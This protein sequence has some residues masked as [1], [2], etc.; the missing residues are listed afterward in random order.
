MDD[1]LRIVAEMH[2]TLWEQFR[3][4]F[5]DLA[6]SL[7]DSAPAISLAPGGPG[8]LAG[9]LRQDKAKPRGNWNQ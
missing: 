1:G 8:A 5:D 4:S 9:R 6:K 3:G 7:A 2:Q